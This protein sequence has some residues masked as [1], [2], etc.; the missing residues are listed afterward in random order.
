VPIDHD[1]P[2]RFMLRIN[3]LVMGKMYGSKPIHEQL[4]RRKIDN[5]FI[6]FEKAGHEPQLD[7]FKR[8]NDRIDIIS[9]NLI[10]FFYQ[11][12]APTIQFQKPIVEVSK[13]S[14]FKALSVEVKN[15]YVQLIEVNGGLQITPSPTETGIIWFSDSEKPSLKVY[16]TNRL[17]AAT[18]K[19]LKVAIVD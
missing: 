16:V 14:P 5:K 8:V 17:N 19:T 18:S 15:G 11:Y 4:E 2:F 10:Q 9:N 1:Y 7:N 12:T 6:I 13:N 3:R